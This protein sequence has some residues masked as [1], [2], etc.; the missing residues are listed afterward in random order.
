MEQPIEDVE[1]TIATDGAGVSRILVAEPRPCGVCGFPRTLF[2]SRHGS[3]RCYE[4]DHGFT[5]AE[6]AMRREQLGIGAVPA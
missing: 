6:E 2:V 5:K 1:I 3:T 4:C